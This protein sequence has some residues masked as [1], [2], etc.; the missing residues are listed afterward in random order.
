LA[1]GASQQLSFSFSPRSSATTRSYAIGFTVHDGDLSFQ[2]FAAIN[3]Y[4]PDPEEDA[5]DDTLANLEIRNMTAPGGQFNVGQ[6]ATISFY[7]YNTGDAEARNIRVSA[8]PETTDIVPVQT[9]S[10]Q[11]IQR[12]APGESQRLTFSFSPRSS[13]TTRSYAI[14]FT[15]QDG[16]LSFQ[17]FAAINVFNPEPEEDEDPQETGRVQ[18]PRVI[19]SAISIDPPMP[20]AGQP[21]DMEVTFRNTSATRSVNNIRVLMEEVIGAAIGGQS[22]PFAGFTPLGG[23]NTL[24]VDYLAPH[25]EITMNLSFTTVVEASPG[26][27]NMRFSFDYQD[28]DFYSHDANQQISISV[29]Q[30]TQLELD[31]VNVGGW[32]VPTVGMEVPF[33]FT[34]INSGRVNLINVRVRAE[35]PFDVSQAGGENGQFVG[36]INSQRTTR[37]EGAIIPFEAGEQSGNFVVWGEDI[38]GE[39]V[40]LIHP[41]TVWVEGGF[42]FGDD[43]FREG[44]GFD[45]G[46]FGRPTMPGMEM[47][48]M[49]PGEIN[50]D[51]ETGAMLAG[52]WD[53]ETGEFTATHEMDP[54]T[55]EWREIGGGGFDFLALIRRPIVWGPAIGVVVVVAIVVIVIVARRKKSPFDLDED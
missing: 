37:F 12:L 2:Q 19:V 11:S 44:G 1:P 23:S 15:V 38:T 28:Q 27:H 8:V 43:G 36:N 4:N 41:F 16:D 54:E 55:G 30:V 32:V 26:A 39:I 5:T 35:G 17:Q 7:V 6:T 25:G 47:G 10:T 52:S 24:F 29:A 42:E 46:G 3:V 49:P 21:F 22:A 33:D 20:R 18:I 50:F 13:A 40:E 34:I 53:W 51:P 45:D 48:A 31:R 14:G 9:A